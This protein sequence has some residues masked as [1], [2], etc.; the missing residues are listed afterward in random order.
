L[1]FVV[2]HTLYRPRDAIAFLNDALGRALGKNRLSW[3]DLEAAVTPYSRGR[4]LALR[5]EWKTTYPGIERVFDAF[6]RA[7]PSFDREEMSRRLDEVALLPAEDSFAGATWVTE[8]S[9]GLWSASPSD[10]WEELYGPLLEVVYMTG[11]VGVASSRSSEP[12]YVYEDEDPPV[13]SDR[14]FFHIHLAFHAALAIGAQTR[15]SGHLPEG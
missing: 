13:V 15:G 4:L 8:R 12:V 5:D 11:L 3:K 14:T 7:R 1:D 2:R 9:I 6:K 10:D